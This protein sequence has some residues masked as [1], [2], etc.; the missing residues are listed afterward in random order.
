SGSG[1][2]H[3]H[4]RRDAR[5]QLPSLA[6]RVQR[7]LG[8]A[9]LLARLPQAPSLRC[10]PGL[11]EA[12]APLRRRDRR[13]P[14]ARSGGRHA[15]EGLKRELAAAVA[16]PIVLA[17]LFVAP[18]IV[19]NA[20]GALIALAAVWEFYRMAEKTGHPVSKTIGIAAAALVLGGAALLWG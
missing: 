19:F 3:P 10:D 13:G 4:Q 14:S 2:A 12:G 1:S 6:D 11:P 16:I 15:A 20:L 8:H 5:I 9:H 7:D 17:A 18:P